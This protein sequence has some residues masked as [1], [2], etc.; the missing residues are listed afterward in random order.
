MNIQRL[1]RW[2]CIATSLTA[3]LA[4]AGCT[5]EKPEPA[6][7]PGLGEIMTLTQMRHAKLWWAGQAENWP[8][9]D[10]EIDELEEGFADAVEFHPTHKTSP[11][12][13]KD[14]IPQLTTKPI[15][16]LRSAVKQQDSAA[17]ARAF[18]NLTTSCNTCHETATFGFNVVIR[19]TENTFSNQDFALPKEARGAE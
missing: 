1:D 18:D 17:F 8:L 11:L 3:V 9:A 5:Q 15:A 19:P 6:Y 10:Y 4:V 12:P 2:L 13:I 14:L 7:T 16:E